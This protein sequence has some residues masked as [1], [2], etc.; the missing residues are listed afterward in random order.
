MF[1]LFQSPAKKKELRAYQADA[2]Q[3]LKNSIL[4]GNRRIVLVLPTGAGKTLIAAKIVEGALSKGGQVVFTAPMISL[5]DQTIA[6]F[7]SEGLTDIGVIQADHPRTNA[8]AAV[9]VASV[10]TLVRRD[11]MPTA[12]VVLIDEAHVYSKAVVDWM[13]AEPNLIFVGLTA[14]PGRKGMAQEWQ[15]IVVGTTTRQLIDAGYLS[16]F[17]VYA[18]SEPDLSGVKIVAGEYQAKGAQ[19]VMEASGLV[20]DIL[21]NYILHGEGRPTLGFGMTVAH[22]KRMAEEFTDAG[23]PSAY[24][25][26]RTDTL[27]RKALQQQFKDGKLQVIWSVRTMTTGVDLPVSGII[28]AAPTR[29]AMLHQQ[30]IGRGLRVNEGT[31]DLKIWDHAGNTLRLGFVDELDWSELRDGTRETKERERKEP[32]PKKCQDCAN[33]M[34][35]KCKECP[36]CGAAQQPPSGWIETEDGDLVPINREVGARDMSQADKSGFYSE[37][38]GVAKDRGY[39]PGWAF[40]KY[41]EKFGIQPANTFPKLAKQPSAKVLSWVR[42]RQIAYAK[43]KS[44]E[45]SHA[46]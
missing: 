34:P 6:A 3:T 27:E 21:Q 29:S 18:P 25:E 41:K 39:N 35:P 23:I 19:E 13:D 12:S 42:S 9:Q 10:Q 31:E 5:I 40:H 33:V 16:Q 43:S 22:A 2:L 44:K 45:A 15:D 28:D 8:R 4:A 20:G 7:E 36:V 30:K 38:L 46:N 37:L 17:T 11:Q 32:L 1:D 24:V 14:T 26:A